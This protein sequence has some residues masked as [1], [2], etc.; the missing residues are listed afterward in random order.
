MLLDLPFSLKS[1]FI[2]SP[3][4]TIKFIA[5][6][7]GRWTPPLWKPPINFITKSLIFYNIS[8]FYPKYTS[9]DHCGFY[10]DQ[11]RFNAV[12]MNIPITAPTPIAIPIF[13]SDIL[14]GHFNCNSSKLKLSETN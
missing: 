7:A 5:Q 6:S 13:D 1:K 11:N 4:F 12:L 3:F 2:S 14:G 8:F 10:Y 9:L